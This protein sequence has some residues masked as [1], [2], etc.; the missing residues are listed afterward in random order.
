MDFAVL[1]PEVN[2]GLMYAGPGPGPMITAAAA[3]DSLAAE[4]FSTAGDY[5]AVVSG[6]TD[7]PWQGPASMSMAGAAAPYVSWMNATAAQAEQTADHAN[8]AASAYETAFTATVP[9]PVIVANRALLASLVSTNVLGQNTPAIAATEAH[10]AEMWAQD[11]AAMYGYAGSS[12]AAS[13]LTPF[14]E[15][16]A[17]T[18]G[19]ATGTP[20]A[21]SQLA[22]AVPAALHGLAS[23]AT[24]TSSGSGFAGLVDLLTGNASGSELST[25]FN[26]IFGSTGLGLNNNMW[27]TLFSSGFYMPGNWLGTMTDLVGMQGAA[28]AAAAG[29]SAAADGI[30]SAVAAPAAADLGE[31]GSVSGAASAALGR[32]AAIGALSVP[33]SWTEIAPAVSPPRTFLD[34][35]PPLAPSPAGAAGMPG[36][37]FAS[38]AANRFNTM[39]PRYGSRLTVMAHPPAAG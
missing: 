1:P 36:I 19:Q 24:S 27:N 14:A 22:S 18:V 31:L 39:T 35:V 38:A 6:L 23:P 37:P 16:P 12:A 17:T 7:G 13:T 10:Y 30:G 21:M 33:P 2:S 3:W 11:A 32:G 34:E 25:L 9:P 26:E 4:M 8:A 29:E 20:T 15:P 28:G 5:G